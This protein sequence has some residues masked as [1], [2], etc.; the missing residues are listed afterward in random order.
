MYDE[1]HK[2]D[3]FRIFHFEVEKS[4][5]WNGWNSTLLLFM[6]NWTFPLFSNYF[7]PTLCL[8]NVKNLMGKFSVAQYTIFY[9]YS[10]MVFLLRLDQKMYIICY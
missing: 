10:S 5:G 3:F 2:E 1:M 9:R 6:I 8:T 4:I 7:W